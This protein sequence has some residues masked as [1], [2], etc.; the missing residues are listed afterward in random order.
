[1]IR[2][3]NLKYIVSIWNSLP[4][5]VADTDSI[6]KFKVLLDKFWVHQEVFCDYKQNYP[7]P[8]T[9]SKI[10]AVAWKCL[11]PAS[12]IRFMLCYLILAR[13]CNSNA[14]N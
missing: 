6:D 13:Q 4:D 5:Y 1:M 11:A 10:Q 3:C 14:Y 8:E 9:D 12:V 2:I 7:E